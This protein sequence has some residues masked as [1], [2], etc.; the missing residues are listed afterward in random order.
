MLVSLKWLRE[1]LD[2]PSE[3]D[4]PELSELLTSAS[5]EVEGIEYRGSDW[6]DLIQVGHVNKIS[7]HPDAD[8]LRLATID[9]GGD[10][11][12]TVVCG[13]PNLDH[14][15]RIAFAQ[16]G[17]T[18][19]NA[20][21]GQD[22]KLKR[23]KIRGVESSGMVLSEAE[24]GLSDSHDGILVLDESAPVG[25]LEMSYWMFMSGQIDRT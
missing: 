22:V 18:V 12:I 2:L 25:T 7:P 10:E 24:L 8:K 17:A 4:V 3:L 15:Q 6:D 21:T 9:Y 14:G 20:Q 16:A 11:P 1:Y 19:K 23:A 5:A 13:A